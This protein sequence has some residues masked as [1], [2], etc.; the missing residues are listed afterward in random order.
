MAFFR[1]HRRGSLSPAVRLSFLGLPLAE[2][3]E[4]PKLVTAV[5]C[6]TVRA[7]LQR[8]LHPQRLLVLIVA[9][10]ASLEKE[11]RQRFPSA[12]VDV[13]DFRAGLNN[14]QEYE[15]ALLFPTL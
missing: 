5:S 1:G 14:P 15:D 12:H 4:T 9:T 6:E 13:V 10:A 8:Q 7:A 3:F 11:I 2:I